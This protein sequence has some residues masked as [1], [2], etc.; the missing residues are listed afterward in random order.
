MKYYPDF[1]KVIAIKE[2][3]AGNESVGDMWMEKKLQYTRYLNGL[4]IVLAN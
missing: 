1:K 4:K 3:S 2:R